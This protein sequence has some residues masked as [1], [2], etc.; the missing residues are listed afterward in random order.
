MGMNAKRVSHLQ[1]QRA[2][3]KVG[4][5]VRRA[6]DSIHAL[7]VNRHHLPL[8]F[9]GAVTHR[10]H[11]PPFNMPEIGG[12]SQPPCVAGGFPRHVGG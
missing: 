1:L 2:L 9:G 5:P 8:Q 11:S 7:W 6:A 3:V 12:Y 10:R 4:L